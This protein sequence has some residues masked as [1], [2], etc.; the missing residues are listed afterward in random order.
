MSSVSVHTFRA[1]VQYL[2]T[3]SALPD[4]DHRSADFPPNIQQTIYPPHPYIPLP[5]NNLSDPTTPSTADNSPAHKLIEH[6][7]N[8]D[9]STFIDVSTNAQDV[10]DVDYAQDNGKGEYDDMSALVQHNL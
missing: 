9:N 3:F 10:K 5:Y 7:L 4:F 1:L 8:I 6:C 2:F